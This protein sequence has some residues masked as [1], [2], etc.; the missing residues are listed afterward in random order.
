ME[1]VT[2]GPKPN[3]L[4]NKIT[5]L[6]RIIR[7]FM[8]IIHILGIIHGRKSLK[9]TNLKVFVTVFLHFFPGLSSLK[10]DCRYSCD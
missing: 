6:M 8:N 3:V 4:E 5:I 7:T 1:L 2:H 10:N 9:F